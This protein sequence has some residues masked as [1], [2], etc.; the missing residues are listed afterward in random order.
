[1]RLLVFIFCIFLYIINLTSFSFAQNPRSLVPGSGFLAVGDIPPAIF[2]L[3]SNNIIG[4]LILFIALMTAIFVAIMVKHKKDHQAAIDHANKAVKRANQA[5]RNAQKA[6]AEWQGQSHGQNNLIDKGFDKQIEQTDHQISQLVN[7]KLAEINERT[8]KDLKQIEVTAAR[9][10]EISQLWSEA[11][12]AQS[13]KDHAV[14]HEKYQ[15]ITEAN[16]SDQEAY[17]NWGNVFG[18]QASEKM[19][20]EEVDQAEALFNQACK[21]Y[22]K[23]VEI[24]KDYHEAYYNW[25]LVLAGQ[26]MAKVLRRQLIEADLI[27]D[28]AYKKYDKATDIKLDYCQAYYNWGTAL[29]SQAHLRIQLERQADA[30]LLLQKARTQFLTVEKLQAGAAA[31]NLACLETLVAKDGE[32]CRYWLEKAEQSGNL[33]TRQ[34]AMKEPALAA[35]RDEDWFQELVWSGD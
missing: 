9:A 16:P 25:G 21:R 35:F 26:A 32:K 31:Y 24:K 23:A 30:G 1:M 27:F 3:T 12:H 19:Q 8:Q 33:P 14:A 17:N 29:Y 6:S 28:E 22:K 5:I 18:C 2:G 15:R 20:A 11:L 10:Y 7:T 34:Q 13:H 4:I